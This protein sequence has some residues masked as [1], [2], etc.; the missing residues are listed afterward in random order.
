MRLLTP[1][2]IAGRDCADYQY[3]LKRVRLAR[4]DLHELEQPGAHWPVTR[5]SRYPDL[6][7]LRLGQIWFARAALKGEQRRA[8]A[9]LIRIA[10]TNELD[11]VAWNE[12]SELDPL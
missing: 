6:S 9:L 1:E 4:V 2:D 12:F 8:R 7:A 11:G 5:S 10:Q 3:L